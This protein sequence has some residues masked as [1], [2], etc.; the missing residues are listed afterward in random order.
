MIILRNREQLTPLFSTPTYLGEIFFDLLAPVQRVHILRPAI[1][2]Q[3]RRTVRRQRQRAAVLSGGDEIRQV[4]HP[5]R[6]VVSDQHPR[7]R[8]VPGEIQEID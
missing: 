6:R 3:Q 2:Q 7:H 5:L 1:A 4:G 8:S